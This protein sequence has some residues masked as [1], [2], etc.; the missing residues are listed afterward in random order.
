MIV[1]L[2]F[3]YVISNGEARGRGRSRYLGATSQFTHSSSRSTS[4]VMQ[5]SLG[6]QI[7]ALPDVDVVAPP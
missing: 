1:G 5:E 6:N 2:T 3:G 4:A 7:E